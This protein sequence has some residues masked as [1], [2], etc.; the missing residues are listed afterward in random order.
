[1]NLQ[2]IQNAR[3]EHK[4]GVARLINNYTEL[5]T[6]KF[7]RRVSEVRFENRVLQV[8]K[9][10]FWCK[11]FIITE[12]QNVLLNQN[13]VGFWQTTLEVNI[14]NK[15]YFGKARHASTLRVLYST[16]DKKEVLSYRKNTWKWKSPAEYN[17]NSTNTS[18]DD[19]LLLLISGYFTMRKLQQDNEG[20]AVATIVAT[21]A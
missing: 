13:T 8:K 2:S 20:A 14:G 15:K 3:W 7:G 17:I 5:I 18:P 9:L 19:I 4:K 11:Q 1:M 6:I 21:S 10:G 12:G 16:A